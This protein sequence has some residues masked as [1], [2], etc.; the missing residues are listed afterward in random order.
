VPVRAQLPGEV[1]GPLDLVVLSVKSQHTDAA[2]RQLGPLLGPQSVVVS[3]QNGVNPPAVAEHVGAD[4]TLGALIGFA[5]D[6]LEPGVVRLGARGRCYLGALDP[7]DRSCSRLP[8]VQRILS[9][10]DQTVVTANVLGY[11]WSKQCDCALLIAAALTDDPTAEVLSREQGQRVIHALLT[12]GVRAADALGL[13]LEP[14]EQFDPGLFRSADPEPGFAFIR[15]IRDRSRQS[16]KPH[17]GMWRDIV[18][19]KRRSETEHLTGALVRKAE[20]ARVPI[21]LNALLVKQMDEIENG[22]R[23]RGWH[24]FDEL[25]SLLPH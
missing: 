1:Q 8:E 15:R 16:Q 4:R 17:S 19:R 23:Q 14:F 9:H 24:N 25:T 22:A 7:S 20:A 12:E 3:L 10:L 5:G 13:Q 2:L 6:Y 11:L 18:V 21:P